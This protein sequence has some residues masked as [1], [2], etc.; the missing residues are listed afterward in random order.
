M[1]RGEEYC[2]KC[3]DILSKERKKGI[4]INGERV[5]KEEKK[6][7]KSNKKIIEDLN[8]R[9]GIGWV[10]LGLF[11]SY[12]GIILFIVFNK[13]YPKRAK[14]VILGVGMGIVFPILAI[15]I[16]AIVQLILEK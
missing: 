12:I 6:E 4:E 8:D 3:Y 14:S 13:K 5:I 16:M 10:L 2:C 11:S 1:H 7:S 15:G 9:G